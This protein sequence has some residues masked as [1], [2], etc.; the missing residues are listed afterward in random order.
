MWHFFFFLALKNVMIY[1]IKQY[2]CQRQSNFCEKL[3]N[4]TDCMVFVNTSLLNFAKNTFE[5]YN[6]KS[7]FLAV[8]SVGSVLSQS[9]CE[10]CLFGFGS[11]INSIF[12]G[13]YD[14]FPRVNMARNVYKIRICARES[15][16]RI[17]TQ[18]LGHNFCYFA[19]RTYVQA[20]TDETVK[21]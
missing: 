12:N 10:T 14:R 19:T 1:Y 3:V 2:F 5:K 20:T 21:Y 9:F 16:T 6:S 4:E 17:V 8:P 18:R 7:H 13:C 15:T 11:R